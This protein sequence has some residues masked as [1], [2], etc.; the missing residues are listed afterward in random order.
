[1]KVA[2]RHRK[3]V[4]P[5]ARDDTGVRVEDSER[6]ARW[7]NFET[8]GFIESIPWQIN[9]WLVIKDGLDQSDTGSAL[10]AQVDEITDNMAAVY[11]A[12]RKEQDNPDI[13][14]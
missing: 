3:C 5:P 1:M 10:S 12:H 8:N 14:R 4:V 7:A 6:W 13:L 2:G 9:Q 11:K